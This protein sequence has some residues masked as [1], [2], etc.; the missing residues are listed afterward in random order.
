MVRGAW[1]ALALQRRIT[2]TRGEEM[3]SR[4]LEVVCGGVGEDT[5]KAQWE[6][7]EGEGSQR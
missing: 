4:G 5:F 3:S 6:R 1:K 2:S 7:A